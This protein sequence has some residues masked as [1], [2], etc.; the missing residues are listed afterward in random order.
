PRAL[1]F[2]LLLSRCSMP[3]VH[4]RCCLCHPIHWKPLHTSI[5]HRHNEGDAHSSTS[6]SGS[7]LPLELQDWNKL[8]CCT[9]DLEGPQAMARHRSWLNQGSCRELFSLSS[10]HSLHMPL[11][12]KCSA[13]S[14]PNQGP[15][16]LNRVR[17]GSE[18]T[19]RHLRLVSPPMP[20]PALRR[21]IP[22]CSLLPRGISCHKEC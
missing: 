10:D 14:I 17:P 19:A 8:Y 2:L 20:L 6:Q 4:H 5:P 18:H 15:M 22:C 21:W 9:G 3:R 7:T 11:R 13:Y 16:L 1:P 12:D